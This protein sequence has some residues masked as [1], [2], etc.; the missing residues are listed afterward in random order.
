MSKMKA[1]AEQVSI[2]MG[3]GGELNNEV[4]RAAQRRLESEI[5]KDAHKAKCVVARK[6]DELVDN[7]FEGFTVESR[8]D[9]RFEIICFHGCGH[10]SQKL[11]R[12]EWKDIDGVH[13][14]CGCCTHEG[15]AKAEQQI[16]D[17]R[18]D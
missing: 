9:G 1:F 16:L 10:P 14:C 15:F 12:G 11:H 18:E 7:P 13:G 2:Q 4:L 5:D 8:S 17:S 6:V 3:Y